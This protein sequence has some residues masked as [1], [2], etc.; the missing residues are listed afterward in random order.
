M[1]YTLWNHS[2]FEL[3]YQIIAIF[4]L[5]L[6]LPNTISTLL[7]KVT[8]DFHTIS[9]RNYLGITRTYEIRQISKVLE[10]ENHIVL[11]AGEKKVAKIAKSSK[12][13][14]YLFERL[15]R[16]EAEIYRK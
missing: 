4:M 12:N 15:L 6:I 2:E 3:P 1:V 5:L 8:M 14:S 9:I 13:F 11:Y 16:T 7:W 10:L